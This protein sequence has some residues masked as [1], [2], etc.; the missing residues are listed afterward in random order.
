M[1][2]ADVGTPVHFW[3]GGQCRDATI[4]DVYQLPALPKQ[5]HLRV[6]VPANTAQP[7]QGQDAEVICDH[8]EDRAENTWHAADHTP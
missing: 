6:N 7:E 3:S 2:T 4:T 5:Y 8:S 1:P